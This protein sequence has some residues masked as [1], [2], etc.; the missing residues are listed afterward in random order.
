MLIFCSLVI[1]RKQYRLINAKLTYYQILINIVK[2]E[3]VSG[4]EA[5]IK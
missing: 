5:W 4:K 1:M 2:I 3:N